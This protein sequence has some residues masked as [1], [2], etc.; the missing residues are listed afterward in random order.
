MNKPSG[1]YIGNAFG[2]CVSFFVVKCLLFL[3]LLFIFWRGLLSFPKRS[4]QAAEVS[5]ELNI[6]HISYNHMVNKTKHEDFW[7]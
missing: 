7:V 4:M 1:A 6:N 3:L 5:L 2:L